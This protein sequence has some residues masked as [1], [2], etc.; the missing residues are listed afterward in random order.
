[1]KKRNPFFLLGVFCLMIMIIGCNRND[2]HDGTNATKKERIVAIT[3]LT[4]PSLEQ[5]TDGF[6]QGLREMG[7]DD[8][9][10][11]TDFMNANGDFSRISSLVKS[12]V[13]KKPALVFIL[14]TPAAADAIK[15]TNAAGIPLVYT[16]V[17][18]P[19]SAKIVS[20]MDRSDTLATGVSDRYP[21]EEQV[22]VFLNIRP[23][24]KS[25]A[26]LYNPTEENS[27]ILVRQ[28]IDALRERDVEGKKYEVRSA[29]EIS[30][31]AKQ[32][33]KAHDCVIV[34]GDNLVTENLATVINLCIKEKKPIF[35]GD[36]DSV[37]KGAIATVG[38]S[39]YDIG[40]KAGNKAAQILDG[41]SASEIPSEYPRAFDYIVNTNAAESMG[42]RI[43]DTFWQSREVWESRATSSK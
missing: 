3:P 39:Y 23:S 31:Q 40:V 27:Q 29:S 4:H 30:S 20:S 35:V 13:A 17:T 19:V 5:A 16:A 41:K 22:G 11:D 1:M 34:N 14:T 15:I 21:V 26:L 32:A 7:Y 9:N 8:S 6:L 12:A 36:P 28:T 33:L 37:R 43:P 42:V 25:A 2:G 10:L 24:M 38:P 18:D